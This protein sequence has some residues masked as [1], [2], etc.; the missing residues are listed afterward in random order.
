MDHARLLETLESFSARICHDLV[1]P[2]GAISNGVELLAEDGGADPE[3]VSLIATSARSASRRLQ[4]FRTAFGAGNTVSG[5]QAIEGARSLAIAYFEEGKLRL[6]W[7][8]PQPGVEARADR[9]RARL[10]L[11]LLLVAADCL[12]RGGEIGVEIVADAADGL[13]VAIRAEGAQARLPDEQRGAFDAA[14]AGQPPASPRAVPAWLAGLLLA[15]M[16]GDLAVEERPGSV[17]LSVLLPAR[18]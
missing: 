8:A 16:G 1:G 18:R 7:P 3:V 12:P 6:S 13:A 11:D 4:F 15:L 17:A 2:V 10:V 9:N 5:G 14:A